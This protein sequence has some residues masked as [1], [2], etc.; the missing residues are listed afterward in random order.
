MVARSGFESAA[1]PFGTSMTDETGQTK[2]IFLGEMPDADAVGTAGNA[3]CGDM[4]RMWLKFREKDGKKV[5][6]RASFQSF[7]CETAIAVAAQAMELIRGKTAAEALS[8]SP[9]QLAGEVGPLP[10][11]KIHCAQLVETA[12]HS[13]LD[14][15]TTAEP[16][17]PPKQ[18][19]SN[20]LDQ[21]TKP[22]KAG[23]L[24][25]VFLDEE[26]PSD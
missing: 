20:L 22:A 13:A 24:R 1:L 21:I 12:L 7:G 9:E 3:A 6:D 14:P 26:K 17:A 11:V 8:Y 2:P 23:G 18:T 25:V 15:E 5:I 16:I 10:P 19:N 4:V